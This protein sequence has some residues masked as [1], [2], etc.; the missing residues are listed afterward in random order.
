MSGHAS[1][2]RP[3]SRGAPRPPIRELRAKRPLARHFWTVV[4]TLALAC[5]ARAEPTEWWVLAARLDSGDQVVAEF[6]LTDLGPGER[7]AAAIGSWV[8]R[9]GVAT[10]F[11]RAKLGGDWTPSPDGRRIDLGKFVFDRTRP[12][13]QLRI[14]KGSL[15]I[16]LD[17][18]LADAPLATRKLAG[19]RW[20][21][22]LWTGGA[23]ARA[24]LWRRGMAAPR[25]AAGRVALSRRMID[26]AESKLAQRRNETFALEAAPLYVAEIASR[27]RAERWVV[28]CDANGKPLAQDYGA[29]ATREPLIAVSPRVTLAGSAVRGALTAGARLA[30]YDP[31]ANLPA[32]IRFLLGL[33]LQSVWMASPFA[34]DVREGA[35]SAHREGIAIASY[36]FYQ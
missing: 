17:F 36:T 25:V 31:L 7:N 22:Q 27:G 29:V 34:L 21:Q 6:T 26:G 30:A 35:R 2:A 4:W 1:L 33:R 10:P 3:S 28:A 18:P 8:E 12:Q 24:S 16:V 32:A 13:A 15:R 14:E 23:P 19:G 9:G 5:A 20:T 11:S